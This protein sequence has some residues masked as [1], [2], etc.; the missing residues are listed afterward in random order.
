MDKDRLEELTWNQLW[1][2]AQAFGFD[3]L[4]PESLACFFWVIPKSLLTRQEVRR[5][6]RRRLA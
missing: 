5:L 4:K 1:Q 3:V 2:R 6:A